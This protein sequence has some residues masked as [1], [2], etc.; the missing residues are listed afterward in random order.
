MYF[1]PNFS[2]RDNLYTFWQLAFNISCLIPPKH[3]R[4]TMR[5]FSLALL[6][7]FLC[8]ATS[9]FAQNT[10]IIVDTAAEGT[11][12]S[13]TLYGLFF[14]EINHS[15]DGGIYAEMIENR[16]FEDY[17]IPEGT[18][19]EN[20]FAVGPNKGWKV[21]FDAD[22]K[23][24]HWVFQANGNDAQISISTDHP[25]HPNNPSSALIKVS[26]VKADSSVTLSNDGFWGVPIVSEKQYRLSLFAK[27]SAKTEFA[28]RI[29]SGERVLAQTPV[30]VESSEWKKYEY[31]LTGLESAADGRLEVVF[32]APSEVYLDEISLFP[33]ETWKNRPNGLRVDLVQKLKDLKPAFLRF[34]GGCIVEGITLP[35]SFKPTTTL[36]P[37]ETRPSRWIVWKYRTPQGLGLH[38]YLQL[39]E[40]I[41]AAAML[42]VNC[43]M[44]CEFSDGG[45]ADDEHLQPYIDEA[46]NSI[47]YAIGP[48]TSKFG[49]LRAAAGHP[50]P[51]NLQYV[52]IGN[53][54]WGREY[55][56]RYKVF[57]AALKAKYP[58]LKYISCV[59]IPDA[60]VD[61]RDD[62]FY[63]SPEFFRGAI[64]HYDCESRTGREV[65][66]GEF[67][68]TRGVGEGNLRGALG[69]AAFMMGFE[70]NGDLVTMSS[71]APLFYNIHNRAWAVN[72]IG[73]DNS[74][75]FGQPSYY[76][77][78]MFST[79]KGDRA[80]PTKV[81]EKP[82][83]EEQKTIPCTV[84]LGA[85]RT[86]VEYKD[87]VVTDAQGK[88]FQLDPQQEKALFAPLSQKEGLPAFVPVEGLKLLNKYSMKFKARKIDGMEGF[89][90]GF[91]VTGEKN[92]IWFNRGGFANSRNVI[93]RCT[94]E[95][96]SALLHTT[97]VPFTKVETDKWYDYE[98]CV[99]GKSAICKENGKEI[100]ACQ[101]N[102]RLSPVVAIAHKDTTSGELL[103]RVVNY[104]NTPERVD[105]ELD[106][107]NGKTKF[108]VLQT[109]LTSDNLT[110]C[111]SVDEPEKV[112]PKKSAFDVVGPKFSVTVSPNSL[113]NL[114][115]Q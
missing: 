113:T 55:H 98:V 84:A 103:I 112:S 109:V 6:L 33:V 7:A 35:A 58:N 1:L 8:A 89:L 82:T 30:R 63:N 28:I 93:E 4:T 81:I 73:F 106:K 101:T 51:F 110:D 75:S 94:P 90:I 76:V 13:P 27:S 88:Q 31:I 57:H 53:E 39:C 43:G 46:L 16:S 92:Y 15:G 25:I 11:P 65:Y 44:A 34:P 56:P 45:M 52:E 42:V 50:E 48:V 23:F 115:L 9:A 41:D 105:I 17:R 19:I 78:Q 85:W 62:H 36:G 32:A 96:T 38:E 108:H 3:E 47:E 40:D 24:P 95:G 18:T 83:I 80:L 87:I 104:S 14:E 107:W 72:L 68:V 86:R 12:I 10:K 79:Q 71:Y 99:D 97:G 77:Q 114:Q 66:V 70:R 60:D 91:N 20:G 74:R 26:S 22:N 5:N 69:E 54:N 102:D 100:L 61:L 2:H 59:E 49:S 37:V 111:N 29:V 64:G 67:A 21:P